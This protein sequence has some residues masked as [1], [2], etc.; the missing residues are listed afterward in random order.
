MLPAFLKEPWPKGR[1]RREDSKEAP[2]RLWENRRCS[3]SPS[4]LHLGVVGGRKGRSWRAARREN[5][6][7][8]SAS[9]YTVPNQILET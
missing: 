6:A 3:F 8:S 4:L 9:L 7:K 1:L 5:D 2:G